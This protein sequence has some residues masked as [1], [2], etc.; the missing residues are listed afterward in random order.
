MLGSPWI[1][2][3]RVGL[4][5][6]SFSVALLGFARLGFAEEAPAGAD[7]EAGGLK[8]PTAIAAT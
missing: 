3:C 6:A 1:M 4:S 2:K 7:L 5:L 8:P